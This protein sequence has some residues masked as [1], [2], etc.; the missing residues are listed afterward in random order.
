M[1]GWFYLVAGLV[2][3]SSSLYFLLVNTLDPGII[4]G[5]LPPTIY[6][7]D[8]II[9]PLQV[10]VITFFLVYSGLTTGIGSLISGY[11]LLFSRRKAARFMGIASA[12]LYC[13]VGLGLVI[14]W[15]LLDDKT[16]EY[17]RF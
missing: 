5:L 3:L 7:G 13:L 17:Y 8:A 2:L 11:L 16:C 4:L 12:P 9:T 15:V 14:I 1:I 10:H 6:I